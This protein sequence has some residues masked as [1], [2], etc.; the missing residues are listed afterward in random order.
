MPKIIHIFRHAK[1]SWL[2]V[3]Q[4]DDIDRTLTTRGVADAYKMG[5]R[6]L[7]SKQEP[8]LIISSDANRALHTAIIVARSIN[9]DFTKFK[10]DHHLYHANMHQLLEVLKG[11]DDGVK[12]VAIFA[13]NPGVTDFAWQT[14]EEI[15][16]VSTAGVLHYESKVGSWSDLSFENLIFKSFDSPKLS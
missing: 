13:H 4:I 14:K 15:L 3:G 1:S 2:S 7:A 16:N 5:T 11:L 9:F 10:V 8:D 12:H 6:L